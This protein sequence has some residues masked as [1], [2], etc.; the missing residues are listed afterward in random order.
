M[1]TRATVPRCMPRLA[2]GSLPTVDQA[3]THPTHGPCR[4]VWSTFPDGADQM[5]PYDPRRADPRLWRT[6]VR[7]PDASTRRVP[8]M[9]LH[10]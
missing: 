1:A 10:P 5:K 8:T 9:E 2:D 7:L 4:T 6:L 3:V